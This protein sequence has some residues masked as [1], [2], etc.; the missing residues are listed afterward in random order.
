MVPVTVDNSKFP[1][2]IFES[3]FELSSIQ[4][5]IM[6]HGGSL[7]VLKSVL[8]ISDVGPGLTSECCEIGKS[9][10]SDSNLKGF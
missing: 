1:V 8:P 7:S 2:A 5:T 4:I 10:D 9:K 3:M 6:V